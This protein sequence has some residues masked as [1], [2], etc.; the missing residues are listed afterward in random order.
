MPSIAPWLSVTDAG[1][2]VDYYKRAFGAIELERLEDEMGNVVVANLAV[3]DADFWVQSDE[4]A[5]P[6]SVA[7]GPV[8]MILSVADPDAVF[9]QA[10]AAGGTEIFPVSEGN[11]WRVGR[12]AGPCG[13]HWEIGRPLTA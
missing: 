10:I 11:G 1:N 7:N 8:R 9:A 2:A 4:T 6:A 13:H 3:G 5:T 12:V